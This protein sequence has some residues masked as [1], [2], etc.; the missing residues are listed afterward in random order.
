[1]KA[2][3]YDVRILQNFILKRYPDIRQTPEYDRECD[4]LFDYTNA[5]DREE[6]RQWMNHYMSK[7]IR[8]DHEAVRLRARGRENANT[9]EQMRWEAALLFMAASDMM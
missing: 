8:Q 6:H 1:M 3:V 5:C 7:A 2:K 4:L 9:A